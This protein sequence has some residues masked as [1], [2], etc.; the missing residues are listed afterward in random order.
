MRN[1]I[2]IRIPA[3]H[4]NMVRPEHKRF[5]M[6]ILSGFI[7]NVSKGIAGRSN[8]QNISGTYTIF[9]GFLHVLNLGFMPL[10]F[11]SYFVFRASDFQEIK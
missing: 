3:C 11:A 4:A 1:N 8:D 5:N 7:L 2:K 6:R 10:V 9:T